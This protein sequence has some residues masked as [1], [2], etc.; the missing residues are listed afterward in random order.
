MFTFVPLMSIV[1]VLT[2]SMPRT[3]WKSMLGG[4]A[5]PVIRQYAVRRAASI[6]PPV[7]PKIVPAPV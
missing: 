5:S 6:T 1:A 7:T 4:C 2:P 3:A